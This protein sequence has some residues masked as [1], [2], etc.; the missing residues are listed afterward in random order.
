MSYSGDFPS[1]FLLRLIEKKKVED[2]VRLQQALDRGT[3]RSYFATYIWLDVIDE[4]LVAE[5][6]ASPFEFHIKYTIDLFVY[7]SSEMLDSSLY[8]PQNFVAS[9]DDTGITGTLRSFQSLTQVVHPLRKIKVGCFAGG[10]LCAG[11]SIA[12]LARRRV[13]SS[14]ML[15]VGSVDLLTV[16]HNCYDRRYRELCIVKHVGDVNR[17]CDT[18]FGFAKSLVGLAPNP[19]LQ[20]CTEIDDSLLVRGTL[21]RMAIILVS[22]SF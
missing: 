2:P 13:P 11:L 9:I 15:L 14:A 6:E 12:A 8:R 16:A 4:G 21:S 17:F 19:L 22:I 1:A 3:L 5:Y 10:V 18:V 7:N 20:M